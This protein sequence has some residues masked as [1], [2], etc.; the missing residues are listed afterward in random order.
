MS[1]DGSETVFRAFD[2]AGAVTMPR[3]AFTEMPAIHSDGS[4]V[5][6]GGPAPRG[7]VL[8]FTPILRFGSCTTVGERTWIDSDNPGLDGGPVFQPSMTLLGINA[9]GSISRL[10]DVSIASDKAL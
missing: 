10:P 9:G 3:S 5:M 8:R 2:S 7:A 4:I 1:R 6:I